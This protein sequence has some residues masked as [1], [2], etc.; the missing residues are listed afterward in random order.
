MDSSHEQLVGY[1]FSNV[2]SKIMFFD[3]KIDRI[4]TNSDAMDADIT[5][6]HYY[7]PLQGSEGAGI[8]LSL[9]IWLSA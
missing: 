3:E 1:T 6:L 4:G 5:L 7:I 2:K 8:L 9:V